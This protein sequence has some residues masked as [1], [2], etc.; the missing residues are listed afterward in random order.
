M[1]ATTP[2]DPT[3]TST[4]EARAAVIAA[5][6]WGNQ[7]SWLQPRNACV[8]VY[9][10]MVGYGFYYTFTLVRAETPLYAPA[11]GLSAVIFAG[12]AV[13][14]W[15][16]TTRIDR[17]S[18]QPL[19]VAVAA[20]VFGGFAATWTIAVHGNS[21]IIGLYA[22]WF[23][24]DFARD[25]GAGLAAPFFEELGKGSGVL[26]LLFIASSVVRTAYDGFIVGAFVGLGF[27]IIE[28]TLYALNSAPDGFGTDQIG[29]SLH[30]V[31][32]RL[33]TGFTSHIAYAAIF[34]AGVV[35]IVGTLAQRRRVG[36]GLALCAT[37]MALH[38]GWDS[39]VA[40]S[41]G[42]QLA[43]LVL[44]IACVVLAIVAV[45]A[46]FHL[47][48]GPERDAMRAVLAPEVENGVLTDEELDAL[49]GNGRARRRYRRHGHGHRD[50]A[51][52]H[53]LLEAGHDLADE[54]A[55]SGGLDSD[56]VLFARSELDRLRG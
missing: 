12:Y 7:V 42:N 3:T 40:L 9:A 5:S 14:F 54:L 16:F 38:F 17:Y 26:L 52:R 8:W 6:G 20:F 43:V 47:T 10:V 11:L 41:G 33:A 27:E 25:W 22:K 13:P 56:R 4:L 19:S 50:K 24:P 1:S 18:R 51:Q 29:N 55:R 45:V 37:S 21:A 36:L 30:T 39:T 31:V 44:M 46:T 2:P 34:G 28:D 15:W 53:H 32:L 48:V 35:F 49:A 23:G